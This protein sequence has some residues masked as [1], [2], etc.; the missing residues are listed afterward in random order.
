[1]VITSTQKL[2]FEEYLNYQGESGV[3]YELYRGNLIEIPTPTGIHIKICQ[4]FVYQ[5]RCFFAAHNLPLVAIVTTAVRT[6]EDSS[7]IPDVV[8][9]TRSLWEQVCA[10][11]GSAVLDFAEKPLLVIEV[12]SQNWRDDYIRK[13]AEYDL[14]D[15]PEY[16]I[17]DPNRPKIRVC[18]RPEN[19]SSYSHQ[20]FLPGQLVQS[21]QFAEFILSVDEV[22]CPPLVEDLIREEQAQR[23]QLE[24]HNQQLEQQVNLERQ[25][26]QRLAQR[27]REMGAD[28]DAEL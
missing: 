19:E 11:P 23:Q 13:R 10:Q 28:M 2:T 20:E 1:M 24:Q 16:W 7:R 15:I 22:L 5:F 17:V 12:T 21:V 18:S 8:I 6:E 4:F 26:A 3:C 9:C 14:I 27:L 25:R